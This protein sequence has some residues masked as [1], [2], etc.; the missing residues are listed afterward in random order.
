MPNLSSIFRSIFPVASSGNSSAGT[1]PVTM[2]E[3]GLQAHAGIVARVSSKINAIHISRETQR[4]KILFNSLS[5]VEFANNEIKN[6]KC[7][8]DAKKCYEKIRS[9]P[10]SD[11]EKLEIAKIDPAHARQYFREFIFSDHENEIKFVSCL[12]NQPE[13]LSSITKRCEHFKIRGQDDFINLLSHAIDYAPTCRSAISIFELAGEVELSD[14]NQRMEWALKL[15]KND[16]INFV[17][18]V[19]IFNLTTDHQCDCLFIAAKNLPQDIA[20]KFHLRNFQ[21]EKQQLA[22]LFTLA[23]QSPRSCVAN[24]ES[25]PMVREVDRIKL[26]KKMAEKHPARLF[27][28]I[29]KFKIKNKPILLNLYIDHFDEVIEINKNNVFFNTKHVAESIF[30]S[31]TLFFGRSAAL[32][33]FGKHA[34]QL[35]IRISCIAEFLDESRSASDMEA[36]NVLGTW[37]HY[38]NLC[39]RKINIQDDIKIHISDTL[40]GIFQY[41]QPEVRYPLTDLLAKAVDP[42]VEDKSFALRFSSLSSTLTKPHTRVF[43][44]LLCALT[45]AS[46]R[47][48]NLVA[49]YASLLSKDGFKSSARQHNVVNGFLALIQATHIESAEKTRLLEALFPATNGK[50]E[51]KMFSKAMQDLADFIPLTN[52]KNVGEKAMIELRG[53]KNNADFDEAFG[54]L[55]MKILKRDEKNE[56]TEA[57][58]K[59][60]MQ[61]VRR[62]TEHFRQPTAILKHA[63]KLFTQLNEGEEKKGIFEVLNRC[64]DTLLANTPKQ[65]FIDSKNN[66]SMSEHLR[67]ALSV[68][69]E[70]TQRFLTR[71]IEIDNV[72][73]KYDK[74]ENRID[75]AEYLYD[76]VVRDRH[77]S[78]GTFPI[79]ELILNRMPFV[80]GDEA[81]SGNEKLLIK[82]LDEKKSPHE[83]ADAI[84]EFLRHL[85]MDVKDEDEKTVFARDLRDLRSLLLHQSQPKQETS[86]WSLKF[87][88]SFED[89]LLCGTDVL[90]S[91]QSIHGSAS[92][93]KALLGYVMQG[94]NRILTIN[95]PDG[96]I[97]ARC[98]V[99]LGIDKIQNKLVM[100]MDQ[101]YENAGMP[102]NCQEIFG[103]F[104]RELS[105]E[106]GTPIVTHSLKFGSKKTYPA[107]IHFLPDAAWCEYVDSEGKGLVDS[108]QGYVFEK[109]LE[110]VD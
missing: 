6:I 5:P 48:G 96:K 97:Q 42:E 35:G 57:A 30:D 70:A 90:G 3:N 85:D 77:V 100:H 52:N 87:I 55:F 101:T 8:G 83:K 14:E 61:G 75:V 17:S 25:F 45:S 4:R 51:I 98:I 73:D 80:K 15:A 29:F 93:S 54:R 64:V 13:H 53:V 23:T 91:C 26:A 50:N 16:P 39:F 11:D 72:F 38:A 20:V 36:E 94:K 32:P 88:Q 62:A 60:F 68:D 58:A 2:G 92:L 41:R 7:E 107:P 108:R 79:V 66:T 86:G 65:A 21:D 67:A 74:T 9:Y 22:L 69:F 71:E 10:F 18:N 43:R 49:K 34:T 47:T 44:P 109:A 82:L 27:Q 31:T 40:Q 33:D 63:T 37:A 102:G 81:S 105:R 84:D 19:E 106:I 95:S 56:P 59:E 99:R 28:E 46:P 78:K 110:L 104:A 24:L 103:K 1:S 12:L 89:F 76:R